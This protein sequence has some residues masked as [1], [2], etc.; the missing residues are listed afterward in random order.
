MLAAISLPEELPFDLFG[1][2][3]T[4]S[5]PSMLALFA[6]DSP[7]LLDTL[8]QNRSL[9]EYVRAAA[10]SAYLSLVRDGRLTRDAAV[11]RLRFHLREAIANKDAAIADLLVADLVS[12]AA[13]EALPEIEEAFRLDLVDPFMVGDFEHVADSISEGDSY[14]E[15]M[16]D[17]CRPT[18]IQDTIEELKRWH[19]FAD[20]DESE[21]LMPPDEEPEEEDWQLPDMPPRPITIRNT[22]PRIGRNDPCPCGSGKKYKKCCGAR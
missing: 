1:D 20:E 3:I 11:D 6:S 5:L 12:Y 13:G 10:A 21:S 17:S 22:A 15:Q 4:E 19:S 8:T 18:G 16:L 7:E 2:A 9:N 14:F